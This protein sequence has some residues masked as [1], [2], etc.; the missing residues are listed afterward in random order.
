MSALTEGDVEE[1]A[2]YHVKLFRP[3]HRMTYD[4]D[5]SGRLIEARCLGSADHEPC[6]GEWRLRPLAEG[7]EGQ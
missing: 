2:R 4:R 7:G 6:E 1:V 5:D 3:R